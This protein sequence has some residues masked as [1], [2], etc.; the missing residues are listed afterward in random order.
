MHIEGNVDLYVQKSVAEI[1]LKQRAEAKTFFR[2]LILTDFEAV[3]ATKTAPKRK[4]KRHR[5][6]ERFSK[7]FSKARR[8]KS[9]MVR[10][11]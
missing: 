3:L 4:R 1:R 10:R 8:K 6:A 11:R 7:R 2:G 5:F 9:D